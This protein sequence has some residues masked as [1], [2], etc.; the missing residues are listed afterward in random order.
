VLII[1]EGGVVEDRAYGEVGCW[2]G[3]IKRELDGERRG[4]WRGCLLN[5]G[6]GG[7]CWGG[8]G[9]DRRRGY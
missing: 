8:G 9:V 5:V 7:G 4:C 6:G 1:K 3:V 2:I